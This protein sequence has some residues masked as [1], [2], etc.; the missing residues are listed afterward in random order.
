MSEVYIKRFTLLDRFFHFGLMVTFTIQGLT[1]FSRIF[2]TTPWGERLAFAFGGYEGATIVH[3]WVGILMIIGFVFHTIHMLIRIRW[4]SLRHSLFG[5]DSLIPVWQDFRDLGKRI[6]W[7]FGLSQKP[8]HRRWTYWEKFDYW[9]VYWGLPLLALTGLVLM[10]PIAFSRVLPGW[11]LNIAALL[12]QAEAVLAVVYIGIIHFY[13][14]H[15]RP[16][17]FPLNGVM[18]SGGVPYHEAEQEWPEWVD[19]LQQEQKL[20]EKST[21]APGRGLRIASYLFGYLIV[22]CGLLLVIAILGQGYGI[23]AVH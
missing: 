9:A 21:A 20:A 22:I 12:H 4:S 1:G 13:M 7:F 19:R 11:A 2:I 5:P 14:G 16:A 8:R 15:F 6:L 10:Y 23:L 3:K 18:F 17:N